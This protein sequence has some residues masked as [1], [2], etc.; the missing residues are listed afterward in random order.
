MA[1]INTVTLV[2]RL[3]RDP[4]L[5]EIRPGLTACKITIAT[6]WQK[7]MKDGEIKK[8][9]TFTEATLWSAQAEMCA[10]Y[11]KKGTVIGVVGRLRQEKWLDKTTQ[12]ERSKHTV[13]VEEIIYFERLKDIEIGDEEPIAQPVQQRVAPKP[14]P[15]AASYNDFDESLP[16]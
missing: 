11:C 4:E 10:K 6:D 12:Q 16:F 2:G 14:Q 8:E 13:A 5:K 3:V 15:K 1:S 7:K 9:V